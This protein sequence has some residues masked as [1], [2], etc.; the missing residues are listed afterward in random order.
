M[1]KLDDI[2]EDRKRLRAAVKRLARAKFAYVHVGICKVPDAWK[3]VLAAERELYELVIGESNLFNAAVAMRVPEALEKLPRMLP[4]LRE[5]KTQNA[6]DV[7]VETLGRRV[8]YR[9]APDA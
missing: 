7:I 1:S 6:E 8:K 3:E 9:H 4:Y 5:P 2:V